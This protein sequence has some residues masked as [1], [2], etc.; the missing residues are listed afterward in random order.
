[1]WRHLTVITY[2]LAAGCSGENTVT[3]EAAIQ[4]MLGAVMHSKIDEVRRLADKG[5]GLNERYSADQS[6]PMIAAAQTMQ[7]NM[8]EILIDHGADI[9]AYD[10]FGMTA[11]QE[12]ET[13]RVMPGSDE[14]KARLRVIAKLK[15]RGY[16][17]PPPK[18]D[19]VLKLVEERRWPPTGAQ[20]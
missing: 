4:P 15:A 5:I 12:A 9:W 19:E 7:W 13:S 2:L 8:V 14:D 10:E 3:N 16:P 17:F 1:M 20:S 11:A 6:T 18:S